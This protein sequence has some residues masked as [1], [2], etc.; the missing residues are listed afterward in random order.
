MCVCVFM[1]VYTHTIDYYSAIKKNEILPFAAAWMN[2]GNIIL[3]KV[4]ERKIL[5]HLYVESKKI[6]QMNLLT[7]QTH[8][9]RKQTDGYQRGKGGGDK[10]GVWD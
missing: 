10:L 7:K 9:H 3:N 1:C 6:I 8:R 4:R 5:Y 2:L